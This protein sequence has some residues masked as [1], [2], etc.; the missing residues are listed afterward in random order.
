MTFVY[1]ITYNY[2]GTDKVIWD[3]DIEYEPG[4]TPPNSP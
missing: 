1:S 4:Y 3:D 2:D